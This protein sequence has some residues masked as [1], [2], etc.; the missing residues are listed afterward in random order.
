MHSVFGS[1]FIIESAVYSLAR[2]VGGLCMVQL[3]CFV[4]LSSIILWC[5]N[6]V[7]GFLISS[8]L[9]FIYYGTF[10]LLSYIMHVLNWCYGEFSSSSRAGGCVFVV[11]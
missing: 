6:G 10:L 1:I 11:S 9:I 2:F 5:E 7:I 3:L 8:P 4:S